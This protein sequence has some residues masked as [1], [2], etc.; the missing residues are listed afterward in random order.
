MIWNFGLEKNETFSK[1]LSHNI[2]Q[3]QIHEIDRSAFAIFTVFRSQKTVPGVTA[4]AGSHYPAIHHLVRFT[5]LG[6]CLF[7]GKMK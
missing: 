2:Y 3:M 4:C 7:T 6:C 1:L 5:C